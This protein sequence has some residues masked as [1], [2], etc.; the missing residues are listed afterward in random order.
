MV[1]ILIMGQQAFL[2][3]CILLYLKDAGFVTT[4]AEKDKIKA[5]DMICLINPD[6]VMIIS[7][8][9]STMND[10]TSAI[11]SRY[12]QQKVVILSILGDEFFPGLCLDIEG[13]LSASAPPEDILE[14]LNAISGGEKR[15]SRNLMNALIRSWKNDLKSP[16]KS[17]VNFKISPR[18][19]DIL[20]F[21]AKG[22]TNKEIGR[23][24]NL[25]PN[26][27]KYL[28][29]RLFVKFSASSRA[30]IVY[31]GYAILKKNKIQ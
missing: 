10:L 4:I 24:L 3:S 30:D 18:E 15:I 17:A 7:H 6:I 22:K 26:T 12:P 27:V 23:E 11:K 8:D 14:D 1:N 13:Y 21:L 29:S 25:S 19:L 20:C 9:D 2:N 28:I 5:L 16:Q 31:K